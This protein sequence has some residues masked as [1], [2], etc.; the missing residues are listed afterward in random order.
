MRYF[1]APMVRRLFNV[2]LT[3]AIVSVVAFA[4][5][6]L[7]QRY[8]TT[9]WMRD[10]QVRA[11]VVGIA[12]RVSRPIIQVVIKDNQEVKRGD[13]LFVI[14][15]AGYQAQ[16]DVDQGQVLNAQS[17]LK[18]REQDMAR[19]TELYRRKVNTIQDYQNAQDALAAAQAQV[20][21]AQAT[22]ELDQLNLS[23]TK[24]VASVDGFVT[25]MNTSIGTY[26]SAGQQLTALV[27]SGSYWVAA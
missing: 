21:S 4:A 19:Q 17:N 23:Y 14:G 22:L 16:L 1:L 15:L 18:Q 20:T 8:L 2:A 5:W 24:I 7:Y 11:N 9:P 27:D 10:C 6:T 13:L 12:P 3:L 25:D 26:V